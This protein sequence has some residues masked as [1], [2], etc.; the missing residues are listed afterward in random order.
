MMNWSI[1][2][3]ASFCLPVMARYSRFDVDRLGLLFTWCTYK[4]YMT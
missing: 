2:M 4:A 3:E 1:G